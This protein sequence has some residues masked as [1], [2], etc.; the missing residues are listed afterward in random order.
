M[1]ILSYNPRMSQI[2]THI[3]LLKKAQLLDSQIYTAEVRLEEIPLE[4]HRIEESFESE[5]AH[6]HHLEE[7]LKKLQMKQKEK[8]L[9]L[10]QKEANVKKLDGQLSQVKTNREYSA[11]QQEIASL[12]ADNSILEEDIIKIMD[13]VEAAQVELKKERER[14]K[15]VEKTLAQQKSDWDKEDQKSREI[16]AKLKSERDEAVKDVEP[17]VKELYET[18]I[19][20]KSGLALVPI[21]GENCGACQLRLRPQLIN[22]VQLGEKITVCES[23][24]RILYIEN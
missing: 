15:E 23:C 4:K 14:L 3:E 20:K 16:I 11:L 1:P 19:K 5:K 9:E 10:N 22:E 21:K 2:Q 12:K 6:L 8:E 24:S 7:V 18:L 17:D 13:E